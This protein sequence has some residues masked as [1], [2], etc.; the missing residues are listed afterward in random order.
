M[1]IIDKFIF[2]LDNGRFKVKGKV[3]LYVTEEVL[4]ITGSSSRQKCALIF[5]NFGMKNTI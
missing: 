5:F 4:C 1:C 2:Q 3:D